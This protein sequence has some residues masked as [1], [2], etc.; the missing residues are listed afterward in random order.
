MASIDIESS[1]AHLTALSSIRGC[2]QAHHPLW[3]AL[4]SYRWSA[5]LSL[6][7]DQ[8]YT[9]VRTARGLA[10]Q[11][12]DHYRS[13]G[14]AKR[15]VEALRDYIST[16]ESEAESGRDLS[17]ELLSLAQLWEVPNVAP[18]IKPTRRQKREVDERDKQ[19]QRL[20]RQQERE[21]KKREREVKESGSGSG[22]GES[23]RATEPPARL[24]YAREDQSAASPEP[25]AL[26]RLII[27]PASDPYARHQA[28]IDLAHDIAR[29]LPPPSLPD[30]PIGRQYTGVAAPETRADWITYVDQVARRWPGPLNAHDLARITGAPVRWT[31]K[32]VGEWRALLERG[33]TEDQRRSMALA[34]SAEA[35]AIARE[36]LALVQSSGD[37]RLKAAGLKLALDSL[38][39]RQSL[40]GADQI[41]LQAPVEVSAGDW[42]EQAAAAGLSAEDLKDIGDIASRA[43]S[44]RDAEKNSK[45]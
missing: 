12:C 39:R 7:Q 4:L 34:M 13:R 40:I 10:H 20:R 5:A 38:T 28:L 6:A 14:G 23:T 32:I 16:M 8:G 35:E 43:M 27:A 26:E 44:R 41:S 3:R 31:N 19:I 1:K 17:T 33:L 42:T 2:T 30:H 21:I 37:E 18:S 24:T 36:A 22:N 15:R 29:E 9:G 25:R 45:S 11:L